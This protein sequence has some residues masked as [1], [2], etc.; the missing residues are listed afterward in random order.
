MSSWKAKSKWWNTLPFSFKSHQGLS[1]SLPMR[2]FSIL[3]DLT[4]LRV[5]KRGKSFQGKIVTLSR[6]SG[7]R[8]GARKPG[9]RRSRS[10]VGS[11]QMNSQKSAI[12]SRP[13]L[14]NSLRIRRNYYGSLIRK[15]NDCSL[16]VKLNQIRYKSLWGFGVLGFWGF[17]IPP[18]IHIYICLGYIYI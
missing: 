6:P 1:N 11:W 4:T 17:Y 2:I 12:R 3:A 8:S 16:A 14:H 10:R 18:L 13:D 9:V 5:V 7:R 15:G